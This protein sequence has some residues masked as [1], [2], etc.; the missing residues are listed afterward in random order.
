MNVLAKALNPSPTPLNDG[1]VAVLIDQLVQTRSRR[2]EEAETR[3]NSDNL[4]LS[5]LLT[6]SRVDERGYLKQI[7]QV[8]ASLKRIRLGSTQLERVWPCMAELLSQRQADVR[9][10]GYDFIDVCTELHHDRLSPSMRMDIFDN[11]AHG[12]GDYARRQKSIRSLL[13]D[14][15]YTTPFAAH[16]GEFFLT[17]LDTSDAQK[18]MS[19]L[20]HCILRRSPHAL[21][22]PTLNAIGKLLAERC[23]TAIKNADKETCKR[24]L[25][26][27]TILVTHKLDVA[28]ECLRTLCRLVN[29]DGVNAWTIMKHLLLGASGYRILRCLMEI[30]EEENASP[31]VLRGAVFFIG[32]SSWGSQ[33]I[34]SLEVGWASILSSLLPVLECGHDVVIFEV[35]LSVQRLIKKYG[36]QIHVEWDLIFEFFKRLF[37]WM[38][39]RAV[40]FDSGRGVDNTIDGAKN[41]NTPGQLPS[42]ILDTLLLIDDLYKPKDPNQHQHQN[43]FQGDPFDFFAVVE[44]YMDFCPLDTIVRLL[45]F[46]EAACYPDIH[47]NWLRSLKDFMSTFFSSTTVQVTI[48]LKA[49]TMLKEIVKS[50]RHIYEDLLLEEVF[51]PTFQHIYTDEDVQVRKE[52]LDFVAAVAGTIETVKF[53]AIVDILHNAVVHSIYHDTQHQAVAWIGNLLSSCFEHMPASRCVRLF[54]LLT[55]YCVTHRD[56]DVRRIAISSLMQVC[57]ANASF[58]MQFDHGEHRTNSPFLVA[59]RLSM[60]SFT[61]TLP[62]PKLVIALLTILSTETH[63]INFE[64]AVEMLFRMVSNRFVLHDVDLTDMMLKLVSCVEFRAFGRA[65]TIDAAARL[66][67]KRSRA[68]T[69]SP[70][71]DEHHGDVWANVIATRYLR[72]GLDLLL[73]L[74]SHL[75]TPSGSVI[76]RALQTF[77]TSLD[78]QP[79]PLKRSIDR[80]PS[81]LSSSNIFRPDVEALHTE[82]ITLVHT[83]VGGLNMFALWIPE[84]VNP[85][86]STIFRSTIHRLCKPPPDD[87]DCQVEITCLGLILVWNLLVS[88]PDVQEEDLALITEFSRHFLLSKTPTKY[89]TVL[90]MH[91]LMKCFSLSSASLRLQLAHETLPY[92]QGTPKKSL[93]VET[94]IDFIQTRV[95]APSDTCHQAKPSSPYAMSWL[96]QNTIVTLNSDSICTEITIRRAT[97]SCTLKLPTAS[98]PIEPL[99]IMTLLYNVDPLMTTTYGGLQRLTDGEALHRALNVLDRSPSYETHKVGVLY[100]PHGRASESELLDVVGGSLRYAQFLRDLGTLITLKDFDGYNAGLD[101]SESESDGK[102]GLLYKDSV[103]MFH[104][105]TLMHH[106]LADLTDG[107]DSDSTA[108]VDRRRG[109]KRHIGNDFVHIVYLDYDGN[110]QDAVPTLTSHFNDVHILVQPLDDDGTLYR[111]Q[112]KCKSPLPPFGPLHGIQ[113]VPG[114]VVAAAARLTA[115]HANLACRVAHQDRFDFVLNAE[116][117]LKQIKQIGHRHCV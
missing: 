19:S 7:A 105:A 115:I 24:F 107:G 77:V 117:R 90:A 35:V 64:L 20:L 41:I 12:T 10:L 22:P 110:P 33:R 17:F 76:L 81:D 78:F 28:P 108:V 73:L 104:V 69:D 15:R 102:H 42:E 34:P 6:I 89:S 47:S 40:G 38:T 111:T 48:R 106:A 29:N 63:S 66:R 25:K 45:E 113:L 11:L 74:A 4:S 79:N 103:V 70:A 75:G 62:I 1:E 8:T 56:V 96:H 95:Y 44:L 61:A 31:L 58:Q 112:V 54:D 9:S 2:Q 57:T 88:V 72:M 100:V 46:R 94:A 21:D 3:L 82:E 97:I 51:L 60:K 5:G 84:H 80:H 114:N 85:V 99:H 18:E 91:V 65:A 52:A 68:V 116:E 36:E 49:L 55:G 67:S 53:P 71:P 83:L 50:C 101:V 23:D 14:G 32:M 87:H 93:L 37:S 86:L 30:L 109:K 43:R 92:L 59:A 39:H 16:L 98:V 26:F 27:M 13:Q